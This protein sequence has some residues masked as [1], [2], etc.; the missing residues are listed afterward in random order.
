[1][2][3]HQ[4]VFT[5][6]EHPTILILAAAMMGLPSMLREAVPVA[7]QKVVDL[8]KEL[9]A[10]I[11]AKKLEYALRDEPVTDWDALAKEI[12]PDLRKLMESGH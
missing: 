6:A 3:I 10:R 2:V 1:M 4:T 5:A 7:K 12:E 8:V 11:E 9:E